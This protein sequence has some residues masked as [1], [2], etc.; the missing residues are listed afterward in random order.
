MTGVFGKL[1]FVMLSKGRSVLMGV[2]LSH[3]NIEPNDA[4]RRF[5][6]DRSPPIDDVRGNLS[7]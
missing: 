3:Q 6:I 5:V 2:I 7:G 1:M 4:L